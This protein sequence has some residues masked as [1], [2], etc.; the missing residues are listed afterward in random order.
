M[1]YNK[2]IS[3]RH[4]KNVGERESHIHKTIQYWKGNCRMQFAKVL[5]NQKF[6]K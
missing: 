6:Y 2:V 1:H 3:K 5:M 4:N